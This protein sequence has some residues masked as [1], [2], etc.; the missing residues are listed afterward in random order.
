MALA[1]GG[2][3]TMRHLVEIYGL[4]LS[5]P[6]PLPAPAVAP[7]D[8]PPDVMIHFGS[9]PERAEGWPDSG[10]GR[11]YESGARI[12]GRPGLV[13]DRPDGETLRLQYAEGI[14][15]HIEGRGSDVWADWDAPLTEADALTFL[16]G[17][18]LGAVLRERGVLVL[19][20]SALV[21]GGRAWAFVG[22]AGAGKSTLAAAGAS[23]GIPVLTEDVLALRPSLGEWLAMPA[24]DQIRLWDE[25]AGIVA[26][27]E[28]LPA[29]TP[30]WPKRAFDLAER[31]L[32]RVSEATRLGG[33]F[34]LGVRDAG[35]VTSRV[36]P[37]GATEALTELLAHGYVNYLLD[38][39]AQ[40]R[41]L[42]ALAAL[43]RDVPIRRLVV[44]NGRAGLEATLTLL[45][46]ITK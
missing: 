34:L 31:G 9:R 4:R 27:G 3:S 24:Y 15:F 21:M 23:A 22:P 39:S 36:E 5:S 20:A 40:G 16:L 42:P 29:L 43:A 6:V 11:V 18:V 35:G 1:A 46:N 2:T 45:G 33:I 7:T 19:H 38:L 26:P 41:E 30:T 8:A 44:G 13:A 37:L 12:D 32:A 28:T 17:P 25:G 14:R 10:V